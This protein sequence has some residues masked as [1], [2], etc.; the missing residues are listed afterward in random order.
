MIN[1]LILSLRLNV[2]IIRIILG[3]KLEKIIAIKQLQQSNSIGTQGLIVRNQS[4]N[5]KGS[6]MSVKPELTT[7]SE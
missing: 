3:L 6:L 5:N 4:D 7:T 1:L 2:T